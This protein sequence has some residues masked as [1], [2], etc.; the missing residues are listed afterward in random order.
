[1]DRKFTIK[2]W[3][4]ST[5]QEIIFRIS[6]QNVDCLKHLR[7]TLCRWTL[8]FDYLWALK[9]GHLIPYGLGN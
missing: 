7:V 8:S 4:V 3:L 2:E 1:M 6:Q 5:V 9:V